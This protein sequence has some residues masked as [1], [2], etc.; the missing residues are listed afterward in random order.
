M[1]GGQG[2]AGGRDEN[3][4]RKGRKG[5]LLWK[6]NYDQGGK[7]WQDGIY[8]RRQ[9]V[10][11]PFRSVLMKEEGMAVDYAVIKL[12]IVIVLIVL[13]LRRAAWVWYGGSR[14]FASFLFR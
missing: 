12:G 13:G 9:E 14:P 5:G 8:P 2:D 7:D 11:T 4:S 6:S 1:K 10:I 3:I